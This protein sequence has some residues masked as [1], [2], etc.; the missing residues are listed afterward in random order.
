MPR[1]GP[2]RGSG[3][4]DTTDKSIGCSRQEADFEL[5]L[6]QAIEH[7]ANYT[8]YAVYQN[9]DT[10]S[11]SRS[12]TTLRIVSDNI[13][14][15]IILTLYM[16]LTMS[17]GDRSCLP[18]NSEVFRLRPYWVFRWVTP[19]W[20]LMDGR[21]TWSFMAEGLRESW[22]AHSPLLLI[23]SLC[24][25][26]V[27]SLIDDPWTR[28]T[29]GACCFTWVLADLSRTRYSEV[30][31]VYPLINLLVRHRI[32]SRRTEVSNIN[33]ANGSWMVKADYHTYKRFV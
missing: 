26:R 2:I 11:I 7:C 13:I 8:F 19:V 12:S 20:S 32:D 17:S 1:C 27:T 5:L 4:L 10:M 28:V 15:Y 6:D 33:W 24:S 14:S 29:I 30:G 16:F 31:R 21:P 23:I 18:G 3:V 22:F 9:H 25:A